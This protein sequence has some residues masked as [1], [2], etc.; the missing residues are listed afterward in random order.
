MI[1]PGS[2]SIFTE[3]SRSD[4][5]YHYYDAFDNGDPWVQVR[6]LIWARWL[7]R[8]RSAPHPVPAALSRCA[9]RGRAGTRWP[10]QRVPARARASCA[11]A[12]RALNQ[13]GRGWQVA[14]EID[15][16]A[17]HTGC[18]GRSPR[19]TPSRY[20]CLAPG[21]AASSSSRPRHSSRN[22]WARVRPGYFAGH[23][24]PR[25]ISSTRLRSVSSPC[26]STIAFLISGLAR[27]SAVAWNRSR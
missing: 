1:G 22:G 19:A 6:P 17:G 8:D 15:G 2:S 14:D 12:A 10:G 24:E 20:A 9:E 16:L 4:L 3:G 5:V 7:A 25:A 18:G 27:D 23:R 13:V 11:C 26:P 21:S